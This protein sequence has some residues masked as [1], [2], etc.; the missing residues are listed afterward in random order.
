MKKTCALLTTWVMIIGLSI[1]A[2]AALVDMYDGT[3]YDTDTGWQTCACRLQ[4]AYGFFVK[5]LGIKL[6]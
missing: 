6:K 3:I 5:L 4:C 2:K 1:R